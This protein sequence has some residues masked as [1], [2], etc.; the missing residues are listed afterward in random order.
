MSAKNSCRLGKTYLVSIVFQDP[1]KHQIMQILSAQPVIDSLR[2]QLL[3]RVAKLERAP[4]LAVVL[5]GN[6]SAS[7]IYTQRK[8]KTATELGMDHRTITFPAEASPATVLARIRALNEDPTV[9]GILIQRPLPP[10]FDMDAVSEWVVPH[11]DVDCF[12]PENIGRLVLGMR[13]PA[14][15][16]PAGILSLLDH[17][18]IPVAGK[19]CC[20]VGRS[21]IVGKPMSALLLNRDSTNIHCHSRTPDLKAMTRQAQIL[22]VAAGKP[23]LIG[24]Q[25]VAPGAIVVDVGIHRDANGKIHGDVQTEAVSSIAHA[26]TPVPGGVGPMTIWTLMANTITSAEDSRV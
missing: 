3:A 22:I 21:A 26:I 11:K 25:H 1:D 17:Y 24:P 12:H 19:I 8:G 18:R 16:T 5:V 13:G 23:H 20:I 10:Q 14:P 2:G 9:D 15:C 6:D 7:V 4:C